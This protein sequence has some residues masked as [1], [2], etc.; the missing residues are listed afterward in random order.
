M[1]CVYIPVQNSSEEVRV[2][3]DQLPRDAADILDILKAEQAPLNL[4]LVFAREYFKQGKIKEFLQILEEGSSPEIDEYYSDVKYDRIAILNALGAYYSNLGKVETKQ[5]ERDEYFI[6]ATHYY[7]KASRI[8]QDEPTTFVGKGQL[9]LAKGDLDQSSEVFKIVIDGRPDNVPAL[10]GQA[11]VEFNR[12]RFQE[13]LEL[14][15]R[16][17]RAHPHCPAAVRLGLGICRYRLGQMKKARQAFE[18]VL[19]LDPE[20]VEA[21]VALGVMDLNTN[22]AEGVR[23]GLEKL[24]KA[25]EIYPYCAMALNHLANHY[26]FTGQHFLVEQLMEAA[27]AATDNPILK[28]HSFYNLARSYHAKGDYETAVVYYRASVKE[29]KS[30]KDFILPFFGLGQVQLKLND[31]K[32]ALSNFEKVMEVQP[33]NGECLKALGNIYFQQGHVDKALESF[34]RAT[35]INPH[36]A[37]AWIEMG[38]LLVSTDIS[39]ALDAFKTALSFLR[40]NPEKVSTELLN[41]IGVLHFERGEHELAQQAFKEALGEGV[42]GDLDSVLLKSLDVDGFAGFA[43]DIG[44][45]DFFYRLEDQGVALDL[46]AGKVTI[47]FNQARLY[48]QIHELE[49][50]AFLYKLILYKCPNYV[51]ACLRLASISQARNNMAACTE[52][53]NESLRMEENN[54]D[55]LS[56]RGNVELKADDWLK[57]KETFKA[58]QQLTDGKDAYSLLALGNWNYYAAGRGEKR[59]SKLEATHLEKARELFTKV[60]SQ[61]PSNMYAANGIGMVLAEKGQFDMAKEIFTQVQE[62]AAGNIT[63]EI[64]DVWVNLAHVYLGQGQFGLAVKM[65]QNCLRKFYH[66]T[67]AQILLY[68]ARTY[69]EAEQWQD[70]KCSLLRAIHL[71]PSNYMLRFDA[72]IAMQKFSTATLQKAKRSA[73]EVRQSVSEL[74]NAL[75]LFSQLSGMAG[76]H[77]HGF[78]GKKIEMHVEYCKHLLDAAKV[79]LEAAEREEQQTKQKQEVARKH[80]MAEEAKRKAEEERK[81]EMERRKQEEEIRRVLEEQENFER[82]KETWRLKSR[83]KFQVDE[84]E[85]DGGGG[86]KKDKKKRKREKKQKAQRD[87]E[88]EEEEEFAHE[89]SDDENAGTQNQL[90]AA[91]LEDSDE[92]EGNNERTMEYTPTVQKARKRQALSDSEDDAPPA[93]SDSG[94]VPVGSE[95]AFEGSDGEIGESRPQ[96]MYSSDKSNADVEGKRGGFDSDSE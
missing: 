2:D 91:G 39:G 62:A 70:C 36:D 35:R 78:D 85:E 74:K 66:N 60:L 51:D 11:C 5:R 45:N 7:N 42:W 58:V 41:N 61:N 80:A 54:V 67:D 14:Y 44:S 63:V 94:K 92:E 64:P 32:S 55:A 69:Y 28:S 30:P 49:R 50:A 15:K 53:I 59:D 77:S 71:A 65:Y 73:D 87:Q 75:R 57:A 68:L 47:L 6:R 88:L 12:G 83:E 90:A 84:N 95:E 27:L 18:R 34:K 22:E 16:A 33:E 86:E 89:S 72:A 17:L 38:E 48:E 29:L 40:K 10:L 26:F 21:L 79:H 56:F 25:Y 37:E 52:M 76:H 20:N 4:W 8:D 1:A 13:S 23:E 9:L 46:P 82:L 19:Q 81:I 93:P 31:L 3:L 24:A 96:E 43:N